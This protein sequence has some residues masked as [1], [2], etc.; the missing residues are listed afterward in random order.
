M[1]AFNFFYSFVALQ[2]LFVNI[3][4]A[5]L[6]SHSLKLLSVRLLQSPLHMLSSLLD[7]L[8]ALWLLCVIVAL[9]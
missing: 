2:I 7:L 5:N 4:S 6:K 8:F 3:S 9:S 1:R